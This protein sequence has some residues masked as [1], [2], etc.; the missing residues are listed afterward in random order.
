MVGVSTE[1]PVLILGD[2][3]AAN[4][5]QESAF[6]YELARRLLARGPQ[7][8]VDVLDNAGVLRCIGG[9]LLPLTSPDRY[10]VVDRHVHEWQVCGHDDVSQ[11]VWLRCD[12]HA[13]T[14]PNR[15]PIEIPE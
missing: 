15:L 9:D 3:F 8:V 11:E 10:V 6:C 2:S 4:Y 5:P 7:Y 13:M 1:D 14:V 12:D